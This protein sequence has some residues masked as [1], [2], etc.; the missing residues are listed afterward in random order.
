MRVKFTFIM[1]NY[2][3]TLFIHLGLLS[4]LSCYIHVLAGVLSDLQVSKRY[5]GLNIVNNQDEGNGLGHVNNNN[6]RNLDGHHLEYFSF[7]SFIFY[8]C[9]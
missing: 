4:Y 9:K 1:L 8:P 2:V 5:I 7:N 6:L 3:F